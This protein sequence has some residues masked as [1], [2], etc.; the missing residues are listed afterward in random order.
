MDTLLGILAAIGTALLIIVVFMVICLLLI[1]ILYENTFGKR[2]EI[3]DSAHLP[4]LNDYPQL[5]S[6][7]A[8]FSSKRGYKLYGSYYYNSN[9]NEF[10]G[11]IVF[12]HG[13]FDGHLSYIPEMAYFAD[14]GYKIFGFDNSGCHM[15][16]GKSMR[17]LPQSAED[18]SAALDFVTQSNTLPLYLFGHSWGGYAVSAVSCYKLYDIKAIFVQSGF[19]RSC[20]M[21][22]E[23]GSRFVGKWIYAFS[24]YIRL[25]ERLKYGKAA[26]YT[27]RKGIAKASAAG[28]KFLILHSTDDKTISLGKSVFANVDKNDNITFVTEKNKGHNSL[29]SDNAIKHKAELDKRLI[30]KYG[31]HY[32]NAN[33]REFYRENEDKLLYDELDSNLMKLIADFYETA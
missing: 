16:A 13:I 27:A 10:K 20:D 24:A 32:T 30:E 29:D 8:S 4:D 33:K 12:S 31:K 22:L 25:Y 28:T 19:N 7:P 26:K 6:E 3:F 2:F 5:E 18:L 1:A 15:S 14:R 21:V 11:L 9:F 17:G 23:E